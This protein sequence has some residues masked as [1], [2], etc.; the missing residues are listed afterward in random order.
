VSREILR[1]PAEQVLFETLGDIEPTVTPLVAKGHYADALRHLVRFR[2]PVDE[3]FTRVM[4]MV[5]EEDLR[6]NRLAL[7][8]RIAG[9]FYKV[10]DLSALQDIP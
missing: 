6:S 1:E 2:A 4:V 3:F 8:H 5:P 9:L 10:A 7:L